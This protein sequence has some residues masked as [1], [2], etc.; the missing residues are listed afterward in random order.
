MKT[1]LHFPGLLHKKLAYLQLLLN[2]MFH[3]YFPGEEC[4]VGECSMEMYNND[5]RNNL[6]K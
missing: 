5:K 2:F 6:L 1:Q 3:F 4:G